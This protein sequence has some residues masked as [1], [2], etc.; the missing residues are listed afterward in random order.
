MTGGAPALAE[1]VLAD[2][3]AAWAALGFEVRD[4]TVALGRVA[5]RLS[6]RAADGPRMRLGVRGA[7]AGDV[8]G[9]ALAAPAAGPAGEAGAHPNRVTALDHVV[10][11]SPRLERT[12]A[13]LEAAGLRLRRVREEPTPAG[14]PRQAFFHL[15]SAIL[16]VVQE[17][18]EAV[19]RGGGPDRPA[20]F[21]GLALVCD[22]L[23]AAAAALGERASRVR[24]AVQPGRR[25]VSLRRSAGLTL[26]L[27]LMS[28]RPRRRGGEARLDAPPLRRPTE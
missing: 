18:A 25:I 22:D 28:P 15:G 17:P 8:D 26:P 6:G 12:I 23:D 9:L 27:A 13:A 5:L 19:E 7:V 10:A 24:D 20:R 2:E 21:W 1:V 16:E 11:M 14:A 4:A 3:P